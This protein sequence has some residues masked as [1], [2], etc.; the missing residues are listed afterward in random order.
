MTPFL[1]SLGDCTTLR[2]PL[3]NGLQMISGSLT[4][5]EVVGREHGLH[6]G[7]I[8]ESCSNLVSLI[9][10][11]VDIVMSALPFLPYPKIKHLALHDVPEFGTDFDE[12]YDLLRRFPSLLS[13]EITPMPESVL[14]TTLHE[15]CPYLQVLYYGVR[16][17]YCSDNFIDVHP[18][19][20]KGITFA[21]L[22]GGYVENTFIQDDLIHFLYLHRDSL[23]EIVFNGDIEDH[24]VDAFWKLQ[25]GRVVQQREY[26]IPL[27]PESDPAG[28][29]ASFVQLSRINISDTEPSSSLDIIAWLI[30]DAPNL[31]D[32]TI[33]ESSFQPGVANA[34][35]NLKQLSKLEIN[36][37]LETTVVAGSFG[38]CSIIVESGKSQHSKKSS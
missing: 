25:S 22:E 34:M 3:L 29:E 33:D 24:G 2:V 16:H 18:P 9:T 26:S 10:E 35:I 28:T 32:I 1:S 14:L 6:I 12:M 20:R 8:L 13:F 5:V 36:Q 15:H 30:S 7:D 17:Y 37:S 19:H 11:D 31:K 38:S 4:H 27:S 21:R 23:E